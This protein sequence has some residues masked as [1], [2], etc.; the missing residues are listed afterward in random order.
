MR[1]LRFATTTAVVLSLWLASTALADPDANHATSGLTA[2]LL[3][4]LI[5]NDDVFSTA[6]LTMVLDPP[7]SNAT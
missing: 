3:L 7:G 2:P 1:T 5:G 6:D 4:A